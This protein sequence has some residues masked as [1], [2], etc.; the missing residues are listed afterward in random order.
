M[1][2][3]RI[4]F[5]GLVCLA[6]GVYVYTSFIHPT[7]VVNYRLTL[8]AL[9]P[10]GP[11]TGSGVIQVSY[12]S[13]CC[14]PGFGIRSKIRV[15]GE[16][17]PLDLGQGKILFV[18]L[19]NRESGRLGSPGQLD[20]ALDAGSLPIKIYGTNLNWEGGG[21][22]SQQLNSAKARGPVNVPLQSL[23][24]LVT[25]RDINDPKS[26]QL[27]FPENLIAAFGNGYSLTGATLTLVDAPPTTGIENR[28][29]WLNKLQDYQTDPNN[30]FTNTAPVNRFQFIQRGTH[31]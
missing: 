14:I 10:D 20:G 21:K 9:T 16:A 3:I 4:F 7:A 23:P 19:T 5:I 17:V 12:S 27:V 1:K 31:L 22:L 11:K 24:T 2:N 30:P 18:T 29:I 25:F 15:T 8:A 28:L 26:V 6:L 13:V